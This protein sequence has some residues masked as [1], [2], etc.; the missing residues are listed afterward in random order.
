MSSATTRDGAVGGAGKTILA[1]TRAELILVT[2]RG[3]NV[4][5]TIIVPIMLLVF[6]ASLGVVN[7]G[8]KRPVDFLLPGML[9]LAVIAT[10]MVSLSIATAYERFY[11]VLKRLGASPLSRGD[12]IVAKALSVL[13]LEILQAA[14]LFAVA[15]LVY[16]W[17][18]TGSAP[19]VVLALVLGTVAFAGLGLAMAGGLRAETTLAGTN[20]LYLVFLLLSG[21]VLPLD[22]LP[23]ALRDLAAVLPAAALTEALR[24]AL[25]AGTAFPL[26]PLIVLAVWAVLTLSVASR[27][28]KWE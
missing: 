8:A 24:A 2:R 27:T 20:G 12:L 13:A 23:G 3:E 18:P 5:I 25:T 16:H 6:F 1:Q 19:T 28:F 26:S 14:L 9:A 15:A 7:A 11:G 4:L 17:R 10:A 22:H 21:A